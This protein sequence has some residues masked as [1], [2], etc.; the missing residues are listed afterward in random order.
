MKLDILFLWIRHVLV[1]Y[2][3]RS[4]VLNLNGNRSHRHSPL[5]HIISRANN[6][7]VLAVFMTDRLPT[8][9]MA[10]SEEAQLL[11]DMQAGAYAK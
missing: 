2:L 9:K 6:N 4:L 3:H 5:P 8:S 11:I 1:L 7:T 10:K